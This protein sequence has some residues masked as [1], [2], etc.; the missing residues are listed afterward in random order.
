MIEDKE[1]LQAFFEATKHFSASAE[2]YFKQFC[3][4]L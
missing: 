2:R 4:L 3:S 1:R